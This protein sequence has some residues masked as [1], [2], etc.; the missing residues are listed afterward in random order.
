[1][2]NQY[3]AWVMHI[4]SGNPFRMVLLIIFIFMSVR[5][6]LRKILLGKLIQ[7]GFLLGFFALMPQILTYLQKYL[8]KF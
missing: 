2:N 4:M 6:F 1:M 8:M 7:A 5:F 3:L